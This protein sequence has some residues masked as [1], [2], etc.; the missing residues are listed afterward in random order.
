MTISVN[1]I[2]F[3][4]SGGPSG[5]TAATSL[6]GQ[7]SSTRITS[8]TTTGLSNITGLSI[9]W[10]INN[11]EGN[12]TLEWV[13]ATNSLRWRAPGSLSVYETTGVTTNGTYVLGGTDGQLVVQVTYASMPAQ[14]KLDTITVANSLNNVFDAVSA[15]DSL[16]GKV[17][18][19]CIYIKNNSGTDTATGVKVFIAELTVGPDEIDIGLDPAGV[20]NGTSTGVA[21]TIV[22]ETTIPTNVSFTRPVT[23]GTGLTIGTLSPGETAALWERRTVPVNTTGNVTMNTSK[24]GVALTS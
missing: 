2:Q 10:A 23:S 9:V 22:N 6:G 21:T 17:E 18:Y 1:D 20:G 7:I 4:Y 11:A 19:R 5:S 14:Y 16:N 12:G 8:Q 24:I 15:I 3:F 13:S